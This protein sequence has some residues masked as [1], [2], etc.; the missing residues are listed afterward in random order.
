MHRMKK[1]QICRNLCFK[2][3]IL[4]GQQASMAADFPQPYLGS[5]EI[6]GR[7]TC[8]TTNIYFSF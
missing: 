8:K 3:S 5:L 7:K 1:K 6:Y 4:I 2:V